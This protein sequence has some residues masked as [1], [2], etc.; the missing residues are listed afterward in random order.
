MNFLIFINLILNLNFNLFNEVVEKPIY[1]YQEMKEVR[2]IYFYDYDHFD[3]NNIQIMAGIY[4]VDYKYECKNNAYYIIDLNN[5]YPLSSL[6]IINDN[7]FKFSLKIS[8]KD[9]FNLKPFAYLNI[10]NEKI[11]DINNLI[12]D[13]P[14]WGSIKYSWKEIKTKP[15]IRIISNI[16]ST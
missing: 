6:K 11:I 2:Y 10:K 1:S 13:S 7:P 3:I 15:T 16:S 9:D 8:N 5:Y 14:E 12:I 4:D